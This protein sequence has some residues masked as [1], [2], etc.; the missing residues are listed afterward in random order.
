[1][2]EKMIAVKKEERAPGAT[3]TEADIPQMKPDEV[4]VKVKATS[5]CG[6]DAHIYA[7]DEWSQGRIKPPM[8]FGHECGGEVLE[9]GSLVKGVKVGDHVSAETH[10]PCGIC[11]QCRTG[12]QHICKDLKILGVDTDGA[13]A[14][15]LTIPSSVLWKNDKSLPWE[16]ATVQEPFG[17]ATYTVMESDVGGKIIAI[18]GDGPIAAFAN[19]VAKAVGACKI[20]AIGKYDVRLG[21]I[22]K[23]GADVTIKISETDPLKYIMD[24]TGGDGVDAVLDMVG[25][26]QAI[27]WGLKLVKKAGTYTAFGIPP[28]VPKLDLAGGVVFKG[29]KIIGINGRKM[30]ETWYQVANLLNNKMVD[31]TPVITHKFPLKDFIKA[32]ET[33]KAPD[34]KA[35]KVVLLPEKK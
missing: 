9:M 21:I 20:Y 22:K 10:I 7:W 17:N 12:N 23:L 4:L 14:E 34:R 30:W 32:I 27:E 31:P 8:I 13:F 1:M 35:S 11:F 33:M 5:I 26:Q 18:I 2:A 29:S 19:G 3:V 15:Y 16:I 6:T 25:N 24:D 28:S